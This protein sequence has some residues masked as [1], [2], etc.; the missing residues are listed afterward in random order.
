MHKFLLDENLSPRL[1][2]FLRDLNYEARAVRDVGL[3]EKA[4]KK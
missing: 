1:T 3:K 2:A 4:M